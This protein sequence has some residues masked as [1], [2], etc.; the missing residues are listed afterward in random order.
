MSKL[1]DLKQNQVLGWVFD[2]KYQRFDIFSCFYSQKYA[3][4]GIK[5]VQN[6][7]ITQ[8]SGE[9]LSVF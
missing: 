9:M 1:R 5:I 7:N 2:C 3:E 6:C 4:S 8:L